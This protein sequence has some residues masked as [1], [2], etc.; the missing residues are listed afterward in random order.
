MSSRP[1]KLLAMAALALAAAGCPKP[2]PPPPQPE[3]APAPPPPPKCESLGEKCTSKAETKAKITNSGLVF[4][5]ATGWIYATQSSCTIAQ[6]PDA[7]SAIAFLGI[8][9]DPKDAKK[10]VAAKDAALAELVK[11]VG[12]P[13]LKRKV[14]WKKSDDKKAI[15]TFKVDFWQFDEAGPKAGK[16]ASILVVS[17]PTAEGKDVIGIGFVPDDDKSGADAAIMKSIESVGKAP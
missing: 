11:Q 9:V 13:P 2:P 16:K 10:E 14:A 3:P 1:L 7:G 4:A 6:A 5:P 17:V 8:D 15:G 12:L